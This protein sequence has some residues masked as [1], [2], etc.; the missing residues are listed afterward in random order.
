MFFFRADGNARIGAG[1]IMRMMT[2][3]DALS[4]KLKGNSEIVFICANE[5]SS[6]F[7]S[8]RGYK[9]ITLGT[10]YQNMESELD[11]WP[12]ESAG[13]GNNN[14]N[15]IVI[16]DS[17]NVTDKYLSSL[18]QYG[19]VFYMDDMQQHAFPVDGI[20]N[21]NV[22][23]DIDFYYS[24][25]SNDVI[26]LIG[27]LY[28]P[29]RPQFVD[30]EY[31]LS[32][33]VKDVL[34]TTGGGDVDN[35]AGHILLTINNDCLIHYHLISGQFNPH[36]DN[37]E[38]LADEMA[39]VTLYKSVENMADLMLNCDIAI[40][41]GGGTMNELCALGVPFICFTYSDNQEK[42]AEYMASHNI[43]DYAG[44]YHRKKD[45]VI[46]SISDLF[47]NN[48]SSAD[49]R[50]NHSNNGKG[51]IDGKGADRIAETLRNCK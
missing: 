5:E 7:V 17:Y 30:R 36:L 40:T 3:A 44:P 28:M 19:K 16:V 43:A 26:K 20:I 35:I 13:D 24:M 8:V 39:N 4:A 31:I 32:K 27:P 22:Y 45:R 51:M 34:I 25:Y 29:L 38:R 2:I 18:R 15:N 48:I 6:V 21:Y 12:L 23:A 49:I 47:T 14:N 46:K 11:K 9:T 10:D 50:E 1:H 41:A 37:L 33:E 42:G